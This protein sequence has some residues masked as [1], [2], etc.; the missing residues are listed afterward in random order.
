M[1]Q[2]VT[3]LLTLS[4]IL[5]LASCGGSGNGSGSPILITP[6]SPNQSTTP[7]AP[8]RPGEW[9]LVPSNAGGMGLDAFYV[10]KYEAKAWKDANTDGVIDSLE[11]DATGS[12]GSSSLDTNLYVPVSIADNQPWRYISPNDSATECESLGAKYHLI[13]NPE[14]MAIARDIENVATNWTGGS[15]GSGCLFRG[16]SEL[17]CGYVASTSPDSGTSRNSRAKHTLSNGS[18]IFDLAGN[19]YEWTDWDSTTAGFQTG[20]TTCASS[21][22]D[23]PNVN[24]GDLSSDDYDTINGSYTNTEGTGM[25]FGGGG[26][27]A[28]RGGYS[29]FNNSGIFSVIFAFFG[30]SNNILTGF[31]CVYRP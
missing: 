13:S 18:E 28:A 12:D 30:T 6:S 1:K 14:W 11:V 8:N 27:A 20:P 25:F 23:I 17:T 22:T 24:C 7:P 5:G 2:L 31:R 10:M 16:N 15:V 21:W 29:N 4:L 3:I 9:V 26:G 19:L